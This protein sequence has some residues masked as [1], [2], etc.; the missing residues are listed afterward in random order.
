MAERKPRLQRYTAQ[1]S[2]M[3][4]PERAGRI[5]AWAEIRGVELAAILREVV[6]A[7]VATLEP[8]WRDEIQALVLANGPAQRWVSEDGELA[9]EFLERHVANAVK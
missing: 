2:F 1:Y 6:A 5:R 4:E 3:D 8:Q 9:P 7:G